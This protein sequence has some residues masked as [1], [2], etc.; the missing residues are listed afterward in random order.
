MKYRLVFLF[1]ILLGATAVRFYG[2]G[3]KSLWFDEVLSWRLQSFPAGEIVG[4]SGEATTVHP[5]LY[6]LLLHFWVLACGDSEFALR[7]LAAV[8]GIATTVAIFFLVREAIRFAPPSVT[9]PRAESA[10]SAGVLGSLLVAVSPF[11]VYLSKQ[12]RGYTLGMLLFVLSSWALLR[13]LSTRD[14]RSAAVR[15]TVYVLLAL[16]FCYTHSLAL[17]SVAAQGAFA[18]IFL[19]GVPSVRTSIKVRAGSLPDVVAPEGVRSK[20]VSADARRLARRCTLAAGLIIFAGNLPWL[21]NVWGQSENL[22]TSW[23]RTLSVGDLAQQPYGALL[24]VPDSYPVTPQSL[25]WSATVV[26]A[27]VLLV[28]GVRGGWGGT[29]LL[30]AGTIPLL[31]NLGY[32]T[33]SI[34]SIFTARYL[35]FAQP[36]WL[37]SFALATWRT[38]YREVRVLLSALLVTWSG[39][40]Y[41][42]YWEALGPESNPGMRG[43]AACLAEHRA[44]DEAVLAQTPSVYLKLAYYLPAEVP[45]RLCVEVAER[46]APFGSAHMKST[47]MITLDEV[48]AKEPVGLWIVT[49]DSYGVYRDI[50]LPSMWRMMESRSFDQDIRWENPIQ[51][52]HYR[53]TREPPKTTLLSEVPTRVGG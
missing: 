42:E 52:K 2:L 37:A 13:M 26:L 49:S 46:K 48:L 53:A 7:S 28:A 39:F 25:A 34:R 18:V 21:P 41:V 35:A 27:I 16:A 45:V 38:P 43:A 3:A 22:R 15:T 20:I 40:G 12:V 4:R 32:C 11:H 36:A 30:L 29:F 10:A 6:F 9:G 1:L 8:A 33:F 5:P 14:K 47:D 31:L 17:F 44:A 23:T 50:P 51:V 24:G 19:W